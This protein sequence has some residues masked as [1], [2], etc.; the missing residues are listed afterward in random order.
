MELKIS[1]RPFSGI[2]HAPFFVI[3]NV[4]NVFEFGAIFYCA[5]EKKYVTLLYHSLS[6][7][8]LCLQDLTLAL[9]YQNKRLLKITVFQF[10]TPCKLSEFTQVSAENFCLSLVGGIGNN[11]F[12][13][14]IRKFS[15]EYATLHPTM[16]YSLQ[17]VGEDLILQLLTVWFT[18]VPTR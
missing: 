18:A 15:P 10:V 6:W 5:L 11:V 8:Y 14:I 13:R 12:L 3:K 9:V 16:R 1:W 17:S 2:L 4:R 7:R